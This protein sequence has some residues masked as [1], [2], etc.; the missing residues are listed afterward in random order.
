MTAKTTNIYQFK[1]A[2]KEI[3]PKI[4]RRIQVPEKYSFW[5]LHV[6]IQNAMG[7]ENYHLHKF[8]IIDPKT[9]FKVEIGMPDEEFDDIQ[10]VPEEKAKIAKY[11]LSAKDKAIYEYDF[12]DGWEHEIVLEKILP[13]VV[14]NQYPKC[15][16]GER[17]CPPEDCGGV[18]GYE[19]LLEIMA[20]QEH[21][22]YTDRMEWLGREFDPEAFDPGS[23]E[24]EDPKECKANMM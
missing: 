18:W 7:W 12:G 14:D 10:I 16:A 11:F 15:I 21:E 20:N 8:E 13:T 9:G 22:E 24:F 17:A 4:W 3:K 1:I 5:D 6:A 23:V 19:G 2:L